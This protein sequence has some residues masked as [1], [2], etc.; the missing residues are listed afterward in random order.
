M[1]GHPSGTRITFCFNTYCQ[2]SSKNVLQR[3]NVDNVFKSK[4]G[5]KIL[6]TQI[7]WGTLL[8]HREEDKSVLRGNVAAKGATVIFWRLAGGA[9][10]ELLAL[11]V[12]RL[13]LVAIFGFL[14]K[15]NLTEDFV[16][17][18]RIHFGRKWTTMVDE[19]T[20]NLTV[21]LHG[22]TQT[23]CS[24]VLKATGNALTTTNNVSCRFF[25][26]FKIVW[27]QSCLLVK[28]A[29]NTDKQALP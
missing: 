24:V 18:P 11:R 4:N 20:L 28:W 5:S 19:L 27:H 8:T 29:T 15:A 7:S 22:T 9:E 3:P 13:D 21:T 6:Y 14:R 17:G 23:R 26:S 16:A 2:Y 1:V 25:R 12:L 10:E